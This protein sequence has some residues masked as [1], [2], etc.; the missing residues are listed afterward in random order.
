MNRFKK[1]MACATLCAVCLTT[2]L[3]TPAYAIVGVGTQPPEQGIKVDTCKL[4]GDYWYDLT[5][6]DNKLIAKGNWARNSAPT[7]YEVSLQLTTPVTYYSTLSIDG[8]GL[9]SAYIGNRMLKTGQ[10]YELEETIPVYRSAECK[11]D[12]SIELSIDLSGLSD[13]VYCL[14]ELDTQGT[15]GDKYESWFGDFTVIVVQGGKANLQIFYGDYC[16][17]LTQY[18]HST[19]WWIE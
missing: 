19:G 4:C 6:V 14:R 17:D 11:G 2:Q 7:N 16:S 8:N 5:I 9:A 18:N 10:G 1:L 3:A 12:K 13:G 15:Q